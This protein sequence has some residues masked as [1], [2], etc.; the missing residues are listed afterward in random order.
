[1][2]RW[3]LENDMEAEQ[4]MQS[5]RHVSLFNESSVLV[6]DD[7]FNGSKKYPELRSAVR[8]AIKYSD[9]DLII[10]VEGKPTKEWAFLAKE[11]VQREAFDLLKGKEWLDFVKQLVK[12]KE[13]KLSVEGTKLLAELFEGDSWRVVTVLDK[14]R[15]YKPGEILGPEA[16]VEEGGSPAINL[17]T[18]LNDLRNPLF[19]KRLKVLELVFAAGESAAKIF[20]LAAFRAKK[21]IPLL[22]RYDVAIKSGKIDYEEALVDLA[23]R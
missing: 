22:A 10:N 5:L 8:D 13:V 3:N 4:A 11:T 19:G 1:M 2:D 17:W 12:E 16:I 6:L 23:T 20:N 18:L 14:L 15:F 9:R 21:E 7:L